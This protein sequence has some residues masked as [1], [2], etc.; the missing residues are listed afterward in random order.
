IGDGTVKQD[1]VVLSFFG[2]EKRELAP[3]F[4]EYV[5]TLVE[6]LTMKARR[7]EIAPT[8][9][10]ERDEARVSST[11]LHS[12]IKE[13]GL[14][15]IKHHVPEAVFKGSEDMQRG[16]LQALF[17]ADGSFQ[18]GGPKGGSVRLASNHIPLMEGVQQVLLNF[19]IASR[20]YRNR[21]EAG[22]REL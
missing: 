18:D 12:I 2:E 16:F 17:T 11:R 8:F 5:N 9:I 19:G 13:Y 1:Q 10:D 22:Y 21:R 4:A 6:P 7:Y 14:A 20:I 15:E 3:A